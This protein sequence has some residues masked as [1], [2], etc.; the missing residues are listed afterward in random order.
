MRDDRDGLYAAGAG[1]PHYSVSTVHITMSFHVI[2][3]RCFPCVPS[4]RAHL[5]II[6]LLCMRV[7]ALYIAMVQPAMSCGSHI[8]RDNTRL[9]TRTQPE[10]YLL[11]WLKL[12]N[13]SVAYSLP[14]LV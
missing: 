7:F 4:R 13:T 2:Y 1:R 6:M 12:A 11:R 9:K 8:V 14:P 5:S 3:R 10:L